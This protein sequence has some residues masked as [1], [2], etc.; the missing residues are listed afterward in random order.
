MPHL[1]LTVGTR[2][3]VFH[4]TAKHTSGGL[5]KSDL[6]QNKSGRIVSRKKHASAKREMRLVKHGF[7]TKKGKFG[8]VKLAKGK[9]SRKHRKG[10]KGGAALDDAA[11]IDYVMSENSG[12]SGSFVDSVSQT[13][14]NVS[15]YNATGGKRRRR[16]RKGKRGGMVHAGEHVEAFASV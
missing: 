5:E 10:H 9:K 13:A 4:G 16:G 8:F 6:M 11:P 15:E 12:A 7:G 2:A 14:L 3:Q 1:H